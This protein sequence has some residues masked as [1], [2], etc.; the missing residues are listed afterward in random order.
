M[1]TSKWFDASL[2]PV[3]SRRSVQSSHVEVDS[4]GIAAR[5]ELTWNAKLHTLLGVCREYPTTR[6]SCEAQ[7]NVGVSGNSERRKPRQ[8]QRTDRVR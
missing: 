6:G 5:L 3:M 7:A 1:D 4:A 8:K 2:L